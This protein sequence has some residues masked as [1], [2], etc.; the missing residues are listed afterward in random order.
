MGGAFSFRTKEVN[1][2]ASPE[3]S[4]SSDGV[5]ALFSEP[6]LEASFPD[7]GTE[8]KGLVE[9]LYMAPRFMVQA[10]YFSTV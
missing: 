3:G 4:V 2:S 6:L 7:M 9:A 5:T 10:E 8:V 1:T